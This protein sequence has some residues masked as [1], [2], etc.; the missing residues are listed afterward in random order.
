MHAA[1]LEA[2]KIKKK[3]SQYSSSYIAIAKPVDTYIMSFG[4]AGMRIC[5]DM[6]ILHACMHGKNLS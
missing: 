4:T 2:K 5:H 6:H 3:L 1:S